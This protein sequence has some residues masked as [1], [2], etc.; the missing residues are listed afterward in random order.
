[1]LNTC[2]NDGM[3]ECGDPVRQTSQSLQGW[4]TLQPPWV[5]F[6]LHPKMPIVARARNPSLQGHCRFGPAHAKTRTRITYVLVLGYGFDGL[7]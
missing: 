2:Q 6:E 5:L 1:M 3:P 4:Q 7:T